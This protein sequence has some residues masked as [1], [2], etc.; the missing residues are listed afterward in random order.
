MKR[1]YH[2]PVMLIL[3]VF[4]VFML[5]IFELTM[6]VRTTLFKPDIYSEMMGKENIGGVIYNELTEYFTWFS[7][8]TVIPSE[9]Y[10]DPL[11]KAELIEG[12][13]SLIEQSL[14]YLSDKNA[15][16][17]ELHYDFTAIDKSITDYTAA[18]YAEM[19]I[20]MDNDANTMLDNTLKIVHQQIED[21]LDVMLLYRLSKSGFGAKAHAYSGV[22][23]YLAVGAGVLLVIIIALMLLVDRNHPRDLPYWFGTTLFCSAVT[24]LIP[25]IYLKRS[26]YFDGFF[27]RSDHIYKSVTNLCKMLLSYVIDLQIFA[28][29]TGLALILLTMIIHRVYVKYIRKQRR[30]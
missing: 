2:Y 19:G 1:L 26:N 15:P 27:V 16:K 21:K 6:F 29:L 10:N 8:P 4:A 12:S 14:A 25:A 3:T 17:P 20:A 24:V 23:G 5:L 22:V 18:Q 9:I 7:V 28:L 11:D 30:R 13:Y